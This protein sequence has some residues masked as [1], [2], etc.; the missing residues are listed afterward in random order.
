MLFTCTQFHLNGLMKVK[1]NLVVNFKCSS[2]TDKGSILIVS[3]LFFGK[4]FI[5]VK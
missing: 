4:K 5:R 1:D 2:L 3:K